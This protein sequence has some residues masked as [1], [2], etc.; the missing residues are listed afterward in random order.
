M[1]STILP[2]LMSI[3]VF[4]LTILC[5][6][7]GTSPDYLQDYA[8][9]SLNTTGLKESFH[10]STHA[11]LPIHDVY[12]LYMMTTC[13]G[14]Y[15][16]NSIP[17]LADVTCSTPSSYSKFLPGT[18][19]T[20]DLALHHSNATLAS[21]SFPPSIQSNFNERF[22][23]QLHVAFV[24]YVMALVWVGIVVAW[25]L[26]AFWVGFLGSFNILFTSSAS[27]CLLISSAIVTA[28]QS[29]ATA[30]INDNGSAIGV[31]ASFEGKF[32]ALTWSA[33]AIN[34]ASSIVWSCAGIASSAYR[35]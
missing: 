11:G 3:T 5:L 31:S 6:K 15:L 13:S 19:I 28:V 26:L 2:E 34:T 1:W 12:S 21:I 20:S 7:A 14:Y 30:V 10:N 27:T 24:F 4:V 9:L 23:L 22:N 18:L 32:V 33:F 8:I 16:N 35:D 29:Q 25:G 17:P